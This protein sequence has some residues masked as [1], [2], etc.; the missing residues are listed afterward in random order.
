MDDLS[1]VEDVFAH[2]WRISAE[3]MR[4][5]IRDAQRNG[6]ANCF[7][8]KFYDADDRAVICVTDLYDERWP[9][10]SVTND[11]ER[12]VAL[13]VTSQGDHPIVYRD[14][15]GN[16]DELRHRE[17]FFACFRPLNTR[18]QMEAVRKVL[19]LHEQDEAE[20]GPN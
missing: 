10:K 15:E 20:Y 1:A 14:T 19:A 4:E 13:A 8:Q 16:W 7:F 11:A 17:G 2:G 3:R 6:T 5:Q 9:T 12:V 18:D